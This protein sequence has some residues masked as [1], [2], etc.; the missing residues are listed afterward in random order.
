MKK[1]KKEG[2]FTYKP[3]HG[4]PKTVSPRGMCLR[5]KNAWLEIVYPTGE[6]HRYGNTA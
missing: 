3:R 6:I 1:I 4:M 2:W 5:E